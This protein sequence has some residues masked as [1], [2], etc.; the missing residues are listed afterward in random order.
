MTQTILDKFDQTQANAEGWEIICEDEAGFQICRVIGGNLTSDYEAWAL[1]AHSA[2]HGSDYH[3][4][5]IGLVAFLNPTER[6]M[7]M[8][9][10][11]F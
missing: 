2:K 6:K 7:I 11:G 8:A 10:T 5:A 3:I 9:A 4:Q 1:V